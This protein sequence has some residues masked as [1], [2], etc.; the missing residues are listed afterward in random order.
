MHR[1]STISGAHKRLQ[2]QQP[3]PRQ[4][5]GNFPILD[6]IELSS[7]LY[8]CSV[9]AP[10]EILA[11]PTPSAVLNLYG[12]IAESVF[13]ISIHSLLENFKSNMEEKEMPI[14][15]DTS[16]A[17]IRIAILSV[18]FNMCFVLGIPDFNM[19]DLI[20]PDP[21]RL[22]TI[23]SAIINFAR[24]QQQSKME[25]AL[26]V[27]ESSKRLTGELEQLEATKS[28][29]EGKLQEMEKEAEANQEKKLAI[30][31]KN[32]A[33]EKHLREM[34][35][36]QGEMNVEYEKLKDI[37]TELSARLQALNQELETEITVTS[38]LKLYV[39][40]HPETLQRTNM[41]L[42]EAVEKTHASLESMREK[43]PL[44]EISNQTFQLLLFEFDK[45]V[46]AMSEYEI[47]LRKKLEIQK[48]NET[49]YDMAENR[50]IEVAELDRKIE[51][52][53]RR[54]A[55]ANSRI[56][57]M[58]QNIDA[59]K[60]S[61]QKNMAELRSEIT[62]LTKELDHENEVKKQLQAEISAITSDLEYLQ[63]CVYEFMSEAESICAKLDAEIS[64]YLVDINLH[65]SR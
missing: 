44:L 30:K 46:K 64:S 33:M 58:E 16:D 28:E 37:R 61:F 49:A 11:H 15:N 25:V 59:K 34:M 45:A 22:Q 27:V 8:Q 53:E 62:R 1:Q 36:A 32:A 41:E 39:D 2:R 48:R 4:P 17:N 26:D 6:F 55:T 57:A 31:E 10:P 40:K 5:I 63:N 60:E 65:M 9:S 13:K 23:L 24:F 51:Q 14:G 50:Q 18:M 29:L 7:C 35:Q 56:T 19:M 47:E 12:Q 43:I 3:Q 52:L 20:K 54:L 38:N 42:R 21:L